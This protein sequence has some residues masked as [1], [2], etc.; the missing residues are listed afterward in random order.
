MN[1]KSIVNQISSV[2]KEIAPDALTVLYGSEARGD[3]RAD[4][5]IDILV[6][7]PDS[8]GGVSF[9]KRKIEIFDR[10][11]DIELQNG[12]TISPLVVL[13]SIWERLKTPFTVNVK[14]EGIR[15]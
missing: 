7:L 8:N 2:L 12:V 15:I 10:L 4:S 3:S 9:A 5:D 11:Y 6:V 13:K 14:N 1:R